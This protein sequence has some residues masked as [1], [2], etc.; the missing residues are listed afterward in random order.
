MSRIMLLLS[1]LGLA[2]VA[3]AVETLTEPIPS[4]TEFTITGTAIPGTSGA[5]LKIVSDG[6]TWE[7]AAITSA[8]NVII[9]GVVVGTTNPSL[10]H[11][12]TVV[13]NQNDHA[14][15]VSNDGTNWA[16]PSAPFAFSPVPTLTSLSGQSVSSLSVQ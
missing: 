6:V 13:A 9:D 14:I 12:F 3:W 15:L 10:S 2:T 7:C 4:A 11:T 8:G 5:S 16:Q 1:C